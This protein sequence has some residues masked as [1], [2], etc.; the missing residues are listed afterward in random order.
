MEEDTPYGRC[1]TNS[2]ACSCQ[3]MTGS[4]SNSWGGNE[5]SLK[6]PHKVKSAGFPEGLM[7]ERCTRVG[8]CVIDPVTENCWVAA[9]P[10]PAPDQ[11]LSFQKYM[12]EEIGNNFLLTNLSFGTKSLQRSWQWT[13]ETSITLTRGFWWRAGWTIKDWA[14]ICTSGQW[15]GMEGKDLMDDKWAV[16]ELR[17][18]RAAYGGFA[19]E[20]WG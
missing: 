1:N 15:R 9:I 13:G 8:V 12:G 4:H 3:N 20:I 7:R 19:G 17:E 10:P 16:G 14:E 11:L 6:S 18:G 5:A 2:R